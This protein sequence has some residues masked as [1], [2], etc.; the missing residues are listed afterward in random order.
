MSSKRKLQSLKDQKEQFESQVAQLESLRIDCNKQIQGTTT[1][2]TRRQLRERIK[3]YSTEINE[4]YDDIDNIEK[5]I[6][7]LKSSSQESSSN[8]HLD[9]PKNQ[10]ELNIDKYLCY[11]DFKQALDTFEK[12]QSQFNQN[13]D[14]ALFFMEESLIKR[15]DLCLKRL[16]NELKPKAFYRNHFRYCPITYTLDNL[17][18]VI[19]GIASFFE[20]K[21]EEVTLELVL[22]KIADSLQRNSV[23]FIEI[24]C[25]INHESD[26]DQLI[27]WFINNFWK[28]LN[29]KV[30]KNSKNTEQKKYTGIKVIAVIS[31]NLKINKRFLTENLSC[32]YNN[33]YSCF[34]W[35]KLLEIPLK[36]WTKNDIREWLFEYSNPSLTEEFI[37]EKAYR[38]FNESLDGV[39]RLVCDAL[40]QQWQTLIY[41]TS[42]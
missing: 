41:P 9:N 23:L 22:Q 38:I 24:N 33:E 28:P 36:N 1:S 15:G 29:N 27:P 2:D 8:N 6:N 7:Q 39:P 19:Q 4:L 42:D 17:E 11:L 20:V 34:K 30:K 21:Q 5:E 3:Q 26:V 25:D 14:L 10:Q 32:Y 13:G 35:D 37:E 16:E 40:E 31:S 12:I 18:A